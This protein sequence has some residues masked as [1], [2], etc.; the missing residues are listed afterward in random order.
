LFF[1]ADYQGQRFDIPTSQAPVTVFTSA[2]R[3]GDFG[4]LCSS[5]FDSSGVCLGSGQLYNPCASFS[6]LCT[7]SSTPASPRSPIPYNKIPA[8]MI[9]PVAANLFSS[10][11]Y[12]ATTNTNLQNNAVNTTNSAF[13]VD[14]GDLK[15]DFKATAKDN[16]SYRFTRSYQNN[17]STN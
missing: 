16:I 11:L 15:I 6:A 17:P 3:G 7:P 1:F 14:Q 4:A 10:S 13:D 12:P 8:A 2:E 9:S 5:G